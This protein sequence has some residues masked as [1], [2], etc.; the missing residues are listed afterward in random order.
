MRR[1]EL[2][3]GGVYVAKHARGRSVRCV[4]QVHARHG[5]LRWAVL[6]RDVQRSTDGRRL[7]AGRRC[8]IET[9][10]RWARGPAQG[11]LWAPAPPA[12]AWGA[13]P[14][15]TESGALSLH[16]GSPARCIGRSSAQGNPGPAPL[17]AIGGADD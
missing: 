4:T 11:E 17:H 14:T 3:T 5:W 15:G 10:L 2:F 7:R 9:F 16:A 6:S 1:A 13:D 8:R 12:Q